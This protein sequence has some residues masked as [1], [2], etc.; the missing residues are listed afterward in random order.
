MARSKIVTTFAAA[1]V[2][3]GEFTV[4]ILHLDEKALSVNKTKKKEVSDEKKQ[5]FTEMKPNVISL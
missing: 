3:E 5:F 2:N 4:K 1:L